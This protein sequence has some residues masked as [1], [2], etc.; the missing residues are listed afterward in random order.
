MAKW[1]CIYWRQH[2]VKQRVNHK[3]LYFE[4]YHTQWAYEINY[5]F[6]KELPARLY[7]LFATISFNEKYRRN[8]ELLRKI[9]MR[10]RQASEVFINF[11]KK[12]WIY[13]SQNVER[14]YQNLQPDQRR[15]FDL[16]VPTM[17]WEKYFRYFSYGMQR[18]IL[19]EEVKLPTGAYNKYFIQRIDLIRIAED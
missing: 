14:M 13:E 8:A 5:F 15:K 11:T 7:S 17:N 9:N 18:F 3:P 10:T 1:V 2:N 6:R 16:Y 12:E 19:K 4:F